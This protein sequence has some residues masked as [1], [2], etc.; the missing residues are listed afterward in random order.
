MSD[1]K[2]TLEF[3]EFEVKFRVDE[4]KLNDWKQIMRDYKKQN[5]TEYKDFVYVDSDDVYYTRESSNPDIDYEFVRYRFSENE[6]RA[7]LTTKR[8]LKDS[9]N[10]IRKEQNV[11]VDQNSRDTIN[12]FVTDGLGYKYNFTITKYVQ[13]Y[14]F[15]DATLPWYT[16]VDEKGNRDTFVEVEVDEQLLHKITEEEAWAIINKYEKILEPLGITPR[17]RLRK[18]L[19]E[20]YKK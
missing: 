2:K 10:I 14:V 4:G 18:S 11:R 7:E 1:D 13:I 3:H 9:N 6:K 8:K 5:P 12:E 19:F 16:V 15:K 20:M 17:N